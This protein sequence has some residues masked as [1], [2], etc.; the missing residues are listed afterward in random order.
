MP[1]KKNND[2]LD[3]HCVQLISSNINMCVPWYIM[4]AYAYYI[5]DNPLLED[6]TFDRLA[7]KILT[8][9]DKIEHFHKKFLT[10][11]MLEAGTYLGQYPSRVKDA[12]HELRGD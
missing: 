1:N 6:H 7:T 8:N 12:V 5:E 4:A 2:L 3:S 9:W 11:E 10:K